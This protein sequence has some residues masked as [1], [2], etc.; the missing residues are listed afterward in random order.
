M[1][2]QVSSASGSVRGR[3]TRSGAVPHHTIGLFAMACRV[4]LCARGD[5]SRGLE[6]SPG[7]TTANY[8]QAAREAVSGAQ[9]TT[10]GQR[11]ADQRPGEHSGRS[12]PQ[13]PAVEEAKAGPWAGDTKSGPAAQ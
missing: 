13:D 4:L 9:Q 8:G 7:E 10:S 11:T 12:T 2:G 5:G 6:G 1:L 3:G